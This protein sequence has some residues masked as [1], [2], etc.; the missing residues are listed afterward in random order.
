VVVV[1]QEIAERQREVLEQTRAR[2][3]E[4]VRRILG[5]ED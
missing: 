2:Y 3:G 4:L 1:I 5:E